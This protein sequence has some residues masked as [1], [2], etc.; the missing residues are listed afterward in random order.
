MKHITHKI[1]LTG[2]A[3]AALSAGSLLSAD[4]NT[5]LT[6]GTPDDD[7]ACGACSEILDALATGTYWIKGR[8]RFEYVDQDEIANE[9]LASTL[10]TVIGYQSGTW[11][12]FRGRLEFENVTAIGNDIYNS[13]TNGKGDHWPVV[14]DP[15]GSEVN[16]VTLD[17]VGMDDATFR[18]GRQPINLDNQRFVGTVGWRQ[19][20]Q[21]YDSFTVA[22]TAVDNL[23]LFYGF[24]HNVN[25]IVGDEHDAGNAEMA[26]HLLNANYSLGDWGSITGYLYMLDYESMHGLSTNTFG[27]RWVDSHQVNEDVKLSWALEAATQSDAGDNDNDV[28]AGYY[29]GELGAAFAKAPAGLGVKV[30]F[31]VLEGNEDE[32]GDAFATP[33]ATGHKFNGWADKFLGTPAEGLQDLYLGVTGSLDKAKWALV[34]HTFEAQ[35]GNDEWGSEIDASI[36]YPCSKRVK[37]GLKA[38]SFSADDWS[39]D[40]DKVWFWIGINP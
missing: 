33:L 19:N 18:L 36:T 5:P 1:A 11:N 8:Y 15:E 21:S 35:D 37:V 27:L 4:P 16:E 14:A 34:F 23:K 28:D 9:A 40:T 38:A 25:R 2:L 22:S 24:V 39:E 12:G 20:S 10:R 6:T 26:S 31:E 7:S 30:G 29:H 17:Y 32:A 13:T 3:T